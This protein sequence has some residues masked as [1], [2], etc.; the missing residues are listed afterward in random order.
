MRSLIVA[1]EIESRGTGSV[2]DCF[3]ACNGMID[4]VAL[5]VLLEKRHICRIWFVCDNF[6]CGTCPHTGHN[7]VITNVGPDVYHG[8]AG[9]YC[10]AEYLCFEWL[11]YS[12]GKRSGDDGIL[13]IYFEYGLSHRRRHR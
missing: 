7:S 3:L 4:A 1:G 5:E 10:F 6:A 12:K 9:L 2:T 8:H 13:W 11:V